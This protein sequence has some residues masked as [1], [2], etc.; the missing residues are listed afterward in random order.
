MSTR[1]HITKGSFRENLSGLGECARIHV[2]GGRDLCLVSL[3]G[4]TVM[5]I[6]D[7]MAPRGVAALVLASRIGHRQGLFPAR[8]LA[9]S[10]GHAVDGSRRR[11][12]RPG[13]GS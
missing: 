3:Q 7:A 4:G 11:G 13:R 9:S 10:P 6:L 12:R 5:V 1:V 8:W 2:Q